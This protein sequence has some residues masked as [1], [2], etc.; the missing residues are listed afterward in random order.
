[1]LALLALFSV[2]VLGNLRGALLAKELLSEIQEFDRD[3]RGVNDPERR[4][5]MRLFIWGEGR[6][7]LDPATNPTETV[8]VRGDTRLTFGAEVVSPMDGEVSQQFD[9]NK[10]TLVLTHG[11]N[12]DIDHFGGLRLMLNAIQQRGDLANYNLIGVDW[13][14]LS[15]RQGMAWYKIPADN[16]E[17]AG[18]QLA[19]MLLALF[20]SACSNESDVDQCVDRCLGALH[21]VGHSLGSHVSGNCGRE[22][23]RMTGRQIARITALDPAGPRFVD[24]VNDHIAIRPSDAELVIAIITNGGVNRPFIARGLQGNARP[25]SADAHFYI[26]GGHRSPGCGDLKALGGGLCSH[27]FSFRVFAEALLSPTAFRG[28]RCNMT[29]GVNDDGSPDWG[30]MEEE[31]CIFDRV[32]DSGVSAYISEGYAP[33]NE[34]SGEYL[35]RTNGADESWS[36][37]TPHYSH[38]AWN[39]NI[40]GVLGSMNLEV[41]PS[42]AEAQAIANQHRDSGR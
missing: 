28:Y 36:L 23:T 3:A 2:P 31:D 17:H 41:P 13:R 4:A 33:G 42:L 12:A 15:A 22:I 26:N 30:S 32:S 21:L 8:D 14:D 40:D 37:Y 9:P 7:Y 29:P 35:V 38:T 20:N 11:Y 34:P 1:M 16:T 18:S 6:P 27:R 39:T 25:V 10:R 5:C 24:D 19:S